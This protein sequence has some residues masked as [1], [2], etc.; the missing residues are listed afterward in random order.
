[1]AEL[2]VTHG[3]FF[4]RYGAIASIGVALLATALLARWTIRNQSPDPR[5]AL[6]GCLLVLAM[7][8]VWSALP[9]QFAQHTVIPLSRNSEP[10]L[11]QCQACAQTAALN[12]MIPL[13]D[14]SGLAFVEM[15]H[16]EGPETLSRLFYLTD[17]AASEA[18]AHANIFEHEAQV[19]QAF[20]FAG[21]VEPYTTFLAQ[22]P[23][24]FVF[25]TYDYPE[26]WLLRKL[27]ADH[28]E[29]RVV[30]HTADDYKNTEL[31]E[32]RLAPE[33]K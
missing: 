16:R 24:F 3:A 20:G 32:V 33:S 28:A 19:A 13:V 14:A 2:M 21:H 29:I 9:A 31:Y 8:G 27:T 5:A 23:H 18:Y 15:N 4:P 30:T 1:M 17:P 7:S 6:L 22:H 10:A 26:D 11:K 25:G 12:P